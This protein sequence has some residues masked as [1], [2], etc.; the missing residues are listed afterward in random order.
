[1]MFTIREEGIDNNYAVTA[2]LCSTLLV[3]FPAERMIVREDSGV[4]KGPL[5]LIGLLCWQ[6]VLGVAAQAN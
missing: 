1:M 3:V 5:A 6:N 4:L 2:A